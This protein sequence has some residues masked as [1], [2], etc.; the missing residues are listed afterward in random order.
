MKLLNKPSHYLALLLTLTGG[1]LVVQG[2][3]VL[4]KEGPKKQR[5]LTQ[6]ERWE[7]LRNLAKTH[8]AGQNDMLPVQ[9]GIATTSKVVEEGSSP[10]LALLVTLEGSVSPELY[11]PDSEEKVAPRT[12]AYPV[13]LELIRMDDGVTAEGGVRSSRTDNKG[14]FDF[15]NLKPGLYRLRAIPEDKD[16][17]HLPIAIDVNVPDL[18][19][20]SPGE[21]PRYPVSDLMLPLPRQMRGNVAWEQR[22]APDTDTNVEIH[23]VPLEGIKISVTEVGIFRGLATADAEGKFKIKG[24][25]DGP[26]T[27]R[28]RDMDGKDI[29]VLDQKAAPQVKGVV[30]MLV[31]ARQ[32]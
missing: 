12:E 9:H 6:Q 19:E 27:I 30:P 5:W 13:N 32:P 29:Q 25:G 23:K 14:N 20:Q 18:E 11:Y 26:Y 16:A 24:V 7:K 22:A 1:L 31:M 15:K 8:E 10:L 4:P 3:K 28:I 2:D 21:Q 17:L